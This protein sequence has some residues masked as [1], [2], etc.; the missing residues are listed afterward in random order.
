MS[1]VFCLCL[2][3]IYDIIRTS[4]KE[5]EMK[6]SLLP[7]LSLM[8]VLGACD[9][10][11]EYIL[12]QDAFCGY[13]HELDCKDKDVFCRDYTEIFV[14]MDTNG[15]AITGHVIS[16]Y[17][18]G[19][20]QADAIVKNGL[21]KGIMHTYYPNGKVA[22]QA[23]FKN[24]K[25]HGPVKDFR[26]NGK[27]NEY[28]K[29]KHGKEY[30]SY[31]LHEN[32]KIAIKTQ[33]KNGGRFT[34]LYDDQGHLTTEYISMD[35]NKST[36]KYYDE[37]GQLTKIEYYD[38]KKIG[39]ENYVNGKLD[40]IRTRYHNDGKTIDCE[41]SWKD[42]KLNGVTKCYFPDGKLSHETTY[43]NGIRNGIDRN[44]FP[45]TQTVSFETFYLY[46]VPHGTKKWF[47]QNGQT[48]EE[49]NYKNG[50]RDGV[51]REYSEC[52]DLTS[53]EIYQDGKLIEKIK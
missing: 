35:G 6:R 24:G 46:D 17:T 26:A 41:E 49:T 22:Q 2:I 34:Q 10:Q 44:Y 38:G 8:V 50:F 36:D 42:G 30:S 20:K 4:I 3:T 9:K 18:D 21:A 39:E 33:R 47:Y 28:T 29:Y 53:E 7:L 1:F 31:A 19:T 5:R 51:R 32:G 15:N 11:P 12:N 40:G 43:A 25:L 48:R 23:F 45:D 16:L 52:G 37:Q 27:L 14:C 13:R